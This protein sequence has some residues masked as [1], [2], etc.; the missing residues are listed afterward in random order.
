MSHRNPAYDNPKPYWPWTYSCGHGV[1]YATEHPFDCPDCTAR[2][3][4]L[5]ERTE[6]AAR[7][8]GRRRV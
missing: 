5:I 6:F 7:L 8:A 2:E 1:V 4:W 3:T